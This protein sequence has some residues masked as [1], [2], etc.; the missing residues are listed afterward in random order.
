MSYKY[1][2]K[3][4]GTQIYSSTTNSNEFTYNFPKN[5]G[6]SNI[7]YAIDVEDDNGCTATTASVTVPSGNECKSEES[8][9]Y[10][11]LNDDECGLSE[12]YDNNIEFYLNVEFANG[13][14]V[15]YNLKDEGVAYP[16]GAKLVAPEGCNF[17][18]TYYINLESV[19]SCRG[20]SSDED[21]E[22]IINTSTLHLSQGRVPLTAHC[23]YVS[24]KIRVEGETAA[25]DM[26]VKIVIDDICGGWVSN[27]T[28]EENEIHI[29]GNL[30]LECIAPSL[31]VREYTYPVIYHYKKMPEGYEGDD[32]ED[33]VRGSFTLSKGK[34][35]TFKQKRDTVY[36]IPKMDWEYMSYFRSIRPI[37]F[38]P[39]EISINSD[40]CAKTCSIDGWGGNWGF[41][42]RNHDESAL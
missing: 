8:Y 23:E 42:I 17:E 24:S 13:Q 5:A 37:K 26:A 9:I 22:T 19:N 15:R 30:T 38:E 31:P 28:S 3:Q 12:F 7:V 36:N 40:C 35:I 41:D 25:L 11:K 16:N 34:E 39:T 21:L 27:V 20:I 29:I 18:D 33:D 10:V 4:G 14:I 32:V 1:V 2:I 6:D